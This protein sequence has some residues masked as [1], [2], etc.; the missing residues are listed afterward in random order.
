MARWFGTFT[1]VATLGRP[2]G[3]QTSPPYFLGSCFCP[4]WTNAVTKMMI[5]YVG[6][7]SVLCNS[8]HVMLR[9]PSRTSRTSLQ[10]T[11][12]CMLATKTTVSD[13]RFGVRWGTSHSVNCV[14]T[15]GVGVTLNQ[16]VG[17]L[18]PPP[19]PVST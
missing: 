6:S 13:P 8:Y 12:R 4:T 9:P 18:F 10:V 2:H 5:R 1:Y 17:N 7:D 19:S 16:A 15:V 11:S 14:L 3:L